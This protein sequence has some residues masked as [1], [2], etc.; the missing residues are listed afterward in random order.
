MREGD[1]VVS[2]VM[3]RPGPTDSVW[4]L[5][6]AAIVA[7]AAGP[8]LG[9]LGFAA[10]G[11]IAPLRAMGWNGLVEAVDF[12]DRGEPLFR[13]LCSGWCGEVRFTHG[14]AA[15]WLAARADRFDAI[16]DD[17]SVPCGDGVAKPPISFGAL[18]ALIRARLAPGGVA[19]VNTLPVRGMSWDGQLRRLAGRHGEARVVLFEEYENRVLILG[20]CLPP[21]RALSE[22]LRRPLRGIGS[23]LA[24]RLS[25]RTRKGAKD[26]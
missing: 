17:L 21:A 11:M 3:A 4:D 6:A 23:A 24:E 2:E 22:R 5:L 20:S 16:V 8:R 1:T 9:L 15:E 12:D 18:P 19:V 13:Q 7:L 26:P 10:G 25:V 14:E